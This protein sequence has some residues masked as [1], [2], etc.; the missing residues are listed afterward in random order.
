MRQLLLVLFLIAAPAFAGA[1][2]LQL[3]KSQSE[4][5]NAPALA[6]LKAKTEKAEADAKTLKQQRQDLVN[7]NAAMTGEYTQLTRG[8]TDPAELQKTM[9]EFQEKL[10]QVNADLADNNSKIPPAEKE[11]A[12]LRQQFKLATW[13]ERVGDKDYGVFIVAGGMDWLENP[14]TNKLEKRMVV[15]DRNGKKYLFDAP[16]DL[17]KSVSPQ[18]GVWLKDGEVFAVWSSAPEA[19]DAKAT[20]VVK[21]TS[22]GQVYFLER[23]ELP[24][25]CPFGKIADKQ[26]Q[27]K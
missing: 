21:P 7:R 4:A 16:Q 23:G 5:E 24:K 15:N 26:A 14:K 1:A 3:N 10:K 20:P 17:R 27:Q 19:A 2:T 13:E 9:K 22:L 12:A 6:E 8:T 25:E 11:A 18:C